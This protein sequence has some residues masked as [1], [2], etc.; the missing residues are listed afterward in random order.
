[1]GVTD[2]FCFLNDWFANQNP[3]YCFGGTCGVQAIFAFLTVWFA[4]GV[5]ACQT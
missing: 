4:H 3:A 1:M 5:G 2:I